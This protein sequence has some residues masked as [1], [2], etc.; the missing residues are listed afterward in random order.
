M[1]SRH[2]DGRKKGEDEEAR[3]DHDDDQNAAGNTWKLR[4]NT[5]LCTARGQRLLSKQRP[6]VSA[7]KDGGGTGEW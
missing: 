2:D 3:S 7:H 5:V 4:H 6:L 1:P